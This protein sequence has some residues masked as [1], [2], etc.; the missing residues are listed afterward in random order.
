MGAD[1]ELGVVEARAFW[2]AYATPAALDR[3]GGLLTALRPLADGPR[4]RVRRALEVSPLTPGDAAGQEALA[5]QL[6]DVLFG[7][8]FDAGSRTLALELGVASERGLL[9]GRTPRSRFDFFCQCLADAQ[10][11]AALLAQRP[12]LV[13]RLLLL[14]RLWERATLETLGRLGADLD[15]VRA[16]LL[17]GADPG[18]WTGV[19]ALGDTHNGGRAV[20]ELVFESGASVVY[21]PRSVAMEHGYAGL[22][23]WLNRAGIAPDHMAAQVLDRGDYGW[24]A[25]IAAAP[26]PDRTAVRTYF[27]RQGTNL[28][29]AYLLGAFDL[30]YENVVAAAGYPV[31]VDLETLFL[32]S[33]RPRGPGRA[34][35]AA[36]RLVEASVIRT[37]LL[38]VFIEEEA[39]ADGESL[40]MDPS[41]L[42]YSAREL[43]FFAEG[44][45]G[46]DTDAMRRGQIRLSAP[47]A[48]SLPELHGRRV[49]AD[50]YVD[51]IVSGFEAAYEL[52]ARHRE[53]LSGADG[54]LGRFVGGRARRLVRHTRV[55]AQLLE[56]SW[57]PRFSSDEGALAQDL[58]AQLATLPPTPL[59]RAARLRERR[60]ILRGDVPYFQAAVTAGGGW[61]A[62]QRRLTGL[63]EEDKARQVWITRI[64]CARLDASLPRP[65][66]PAR[67]AR[68]DDD[69]ILAA[70]C[71]VADRL[72]ALALSAGARAS[73]IVPHPGTG[74]RLTPQPAYLDLYQGLAGIALFLGGLSLKSKDRE[75]LRLA[76]S[77]LAEALDIRRDAPAEI[78][79]IGAYDGLAG[80][81]WTLATLGRLLNRDDWLREAVAI[82]LESA[83][84]AAQD[85]SVDVISGRAGFLLAGWAVAEMT[86]EAALAKALAPCAASLMNVPESQLPP[87]A[88]AG[89]AHGCAGL[90]FALTRH[91]QACADAAAGETGR[92]L[93]ARDLAEVEA[94]MASPDDLDSRG[95]LA[96][97]RG[98]LGAALAAINIKYP[99]AQLGALVARVAADLAAPA[100]GAALCLCHGA[101]GVMEFLAAARHAGALGAG[102]AYHDLRDRILCEF[103]A[104]SFCAD[105]T[106]R[107]ET[108]GLMTGLAGSGWTL[109]RLLDPETFPSVLMLAPSRRTARTAT[110]P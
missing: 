63:S 30:H 1:S 88:E 16:E 86:G 44:W 47:A 3:P 32:G 40:G 59:P 65:R 66:R 95:M 100:G 25:W 6:E 8:L 96:W 109:L 91:G 97:C 10:F 13:R 52:F 15:A 37:L 5:T 87:P 85:P 110:C 92:A 2:A 76:E 50:A 83:E 70:A 90:G 99:P 62:S 68:I 77:A 45:Q 53:D 39:G 103:Q 60:A 57:H 9:A 27:K 69:A 21:K 58:D 28:A 24:A 82:T 93:I 43:R 46:L 35:R 102:T 38:P 56:R 80:L 107:I 12:A 73:W 101:L 78:S 74:V 31:M 54:L 34:S 36:S 75:H 64:A 33:A 29:L 108:P 67:A 49:P 11:A 72:S 4:R 61:R 98:G 7:R 14:I 41:A 106:H 105:H 20:Q 42:G 18:A 79:P 84:R 81:A 17:A 104:G 19:H 51:E 55:Y 23:E 89:L 48:A 71:C 94:F 26:C 22:V